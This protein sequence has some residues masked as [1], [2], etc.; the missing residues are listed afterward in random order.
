[1]YEEI[2]EQA[3]RLA[4]MAI[5]F[6]HPMIPATGRAVIHESARLIHAMA[7]RLETL[8]QRLQM[9]REARKEQ[10]QMIADLMEGAASEQTAKR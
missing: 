7:E 8:E 5:G 9:E 1:M 2:T 6:N 10:G 3:E 4:T